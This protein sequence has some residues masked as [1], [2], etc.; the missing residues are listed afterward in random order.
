MRPV[1]TRSDQP[2]PATAEMLVERSAGSGRRQAP[3]KA[4]SSDRHGVARAHHLDGGPTGSPRIEDREGQSEDSPG[5]LVIHELDAS[6]GTLSE[7][8][9]DRQ[10]ESGPWG[11]AR[12]SR[13][14]PVEPLEDTVPLRIGHPGSVIDHIPYGLDLS[15]QRRAAR[16][17]Y[18]SAC[19]SAYGAS[20]RSRR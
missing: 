2:R 7:A 1:A 13:V 14:S 15:R 11:T 18:G 12:A 9:G 8:T 20:A 17:G 5:S 10:S 19:P 3:V 16:S 4:V 6:P